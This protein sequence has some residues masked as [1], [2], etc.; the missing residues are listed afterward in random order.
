ML[1]RWFKFTRANFVS[2][3][4]FFPYLP[5][6]KHRGCNNVIVLSSIPEIVGLL[7]LLVVSQMHVKIHFKSRN[8]YTN[9]TLNLTVPSQCGNHHILALGSGLIR[10]P[11]EL[12][13]GAWYR[14]GLNSPTLIY[15]LWGLG[16]GMLFC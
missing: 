10:T 13:G 1:S 4:G 15:W 8:V 2:S 9:T 16:V 11:Q 7:L 12:S 14:R 6:S 5:P 3:H